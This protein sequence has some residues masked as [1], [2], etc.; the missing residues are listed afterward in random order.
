MTRSK[1]SSEDGSLYV[2]GTWVARLGRLLDATVRLT[3]ARRGE[4]RHAVA[5]CSSS[6]SVDSEDE[7][8]LYEC[9]WRL[10]LRTGREGVP[11]AAAACVEEAIYANRPLSRGVGYRGA[12]R[13]GAGVD[14]APAACPRA[15]HLTWLVR[16]DPSNDGRAFERASEHAGVAQGCSC[17]DATRK[18]T[19]R[20]G[21]S[22]GKSDD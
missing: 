10:L 12:V 19:S 8:S 11:T 17:H 7:L 20:G 22:G 21:K 3:L 5:R 15:L 9:I 18:G 16:R 2:R 6:S 14:L 13:S 4:P 1:S